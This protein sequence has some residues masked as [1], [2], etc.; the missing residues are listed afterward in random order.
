MKRSTV[1]AAEHLKGW[2]SEIIDKFHEGCING[3]EAKLSIWNE[4]Q[5]TLFDLNPKHFK[6][7]VWL[8][9]SVSAGDPEAVRT[10]FEVLTKG[11]E[12]VSSRYMG[13]RDESNDKG[14]FYLTI[15]T[16]DIDSAAELVD[17]L[18]N[19]GFEIRDWSFGANRR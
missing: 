17:C 15:A 11:E 14:V 3:V 8:R 19:E 5:A 9:V 6:N 10:L 2:T 18:T 13:P 4:I 12:V 1:R 16:H 7:V